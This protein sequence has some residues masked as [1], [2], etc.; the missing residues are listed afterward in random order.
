MMTTTPPAQTGAANNGNNNL[1]NSNQN[2]KKRTKKK[3][4]KQ[5]KNKGQNKLFRGATTDGPMNGIVIAT[6]RPTPTSG[7]IDKFMKGLQAY[8]NQNG[9]AHVADCIHNIEDLTKDDFKPEQI[10][11]SDCVTKVEV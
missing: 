1:N 5:N 11:F 7:L 6:D 4:W 8:A 3:T 9:M 2:S 10:D